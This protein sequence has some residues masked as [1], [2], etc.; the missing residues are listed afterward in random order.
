[1]NYIVR[2][3]I[4]TDFPQIM[5]LWMETDLSKPER[6]DNELTIKST[7]NLGGKLLVLEDSENKKILGTSWITTDGRRL[8]LHHF[9]I[10]PSHQGQKLSHMLLKASLDFAKKTNMQIKLEVHKD[11]FI[12]NN[13]YENAGFKYLGDYK[14]LIIR[15]YT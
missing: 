2:D 14:V 5:N 13:L 1:M 11:N 9:G 8:Y 3:Y 6:G 4:N 7:L 15:K 12:A 10:K